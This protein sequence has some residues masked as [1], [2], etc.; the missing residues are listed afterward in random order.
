MK[1]L[2]YMQV[3]DNNDLLW[4]CI[5]HNDIRQFSGQAVVNFLLFYYLIC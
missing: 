5:N 3:R 2:N 1:N 4:N